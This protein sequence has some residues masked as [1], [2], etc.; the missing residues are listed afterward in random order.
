MRRAERRRIDSRN[1]HGDGETDDGLRVGGDAALSSDTRGNLDVSGGGI[2]GTN[3]LTDC[4]W[5]GLVQEPFNHFG[6]RIGIA[7]WFQKT[8]DVRDFIAG[9]DERQVQNIF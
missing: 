6:G 5:N 4:G 2:G 3:R 8:R 9:G 7:S 1:C